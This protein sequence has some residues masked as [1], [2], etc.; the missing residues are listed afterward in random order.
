MMEAGTKKDSQNAFHNAAFDYDSIELATN[1]E[2]GHSNGTSAAAVVEN[3]ATQ[4]Q[5]DRGQW[6]SGIEFLMSC[7]A[8]SVG[9]GNIWRFPFT[10]YEN[11]GG[12]FLIPYIIMLLLIGRPV[13]YLEMCLG[14]FTSRAN[15]KTF[16]ALAPCL[17][18]NLFNH[19]AHFIQSPPKCLCRYWLWPDHRVHLRGHVLLLPDGDYLILFPEFVH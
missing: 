12:A 2:N 17:K 14:Q 9:L 13:Y 8:M 1:K 4:E 10:A 11:G 3:G 6:G 5:P 18:G 15:V 16:E 19:E 7:I